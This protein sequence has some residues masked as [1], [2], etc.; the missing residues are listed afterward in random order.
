MSKYNNSYISR[1]QEKYAYHEKI[2]HAIDCIN[3]LERSLSSKAQVYERLLIYN[4]QLKT[5]LGTGPVV[6]TDRNYIYRCEDC[7][8]QGRHVEGLRDARTAFTHQDRYH[9][10][11]GAKLST[12]VGR[13]ARQPSKAPS[14]D[15][16][17]LLKCRH[18]QTSTFDS[19]VLQLHSLL[20]KDLVLFQCPW[21][22]CNQLFGVPS[23]LKRSVSSI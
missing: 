19:S 11:L 20:H 4:R 13:V 2:M 7:H 16:L 22:Q 6:R 10:I 17:H 1:L 14:N 15:S 3:K 21:P 18:C 9:P 5:K 12:K 8:R 23:K